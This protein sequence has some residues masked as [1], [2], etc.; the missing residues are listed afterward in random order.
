MQNDDD[1]ARDRSEF[2]AWCAGDREAGAALVRRHF[3]AIFAFFH[4]RLHG[5]A[6]DLAQRTFLA[7]LEQRDS[8]RAEGSFRAYLFGIARRQ[9]LRAYERDEML[10]RRAALARTTARSPSPSGLVMAEQ[11]RE[12]LHRALRELPMEQ[13]LLLELH[14]WDRLSTEEIAVAIDT[15]R[16]NVNPRVA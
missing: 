15:S 5:H 3:A 1:A 9:L 12:L 6:E 2:A 11:Q 10:G 14:Y 8:Y 16:D 7:C 13:Q 4:A